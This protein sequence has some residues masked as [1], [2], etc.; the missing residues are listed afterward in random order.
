LSRLSAEANETVEVVQGAKEAGARITRFLDRASE[1]VSVCTD[2]RGLSIAMQMKALK[3]FRS[4]P[5][6]GL[7]V[8]FV[9]EI[10][11][12]NE[13]FAKMLSGFVE[14]RHLE[15]VAGIFAVSDAGEFISGVV[16][17]EGSPVTELV[18]SNAR[19]IVSQHSYLFE[20]LWRK[21]VPAESRMRELDQA[22]PPTRTNLLEG[23]KEV[24]QQIARMIDPAGEIV[25]CMASGG[26]GMVLDSIAEAISLAASE[27]PRG[28]LGR[29]RWLTSIDEDDAELAKACLALGVEVRHTSSMPPLS[30]VCSRSDILASIESSGQRTLLQNVLSSN[31]PAYVRHFL[32]LFEE[33]WKDGADAQKR[34][35][36]IASGVEP[37]NV[38]VIENP[39]ES[40][41]VAWEMIGTSREILLMFSTPR[42]FLRQAK[43]GAFETLKPLVGKS[44]SSVKILI[45][46]EESV[47]P[48]LEQVKKEV[49][50]ADFRVMNESL[51]T[52]ISILIADRSKTLVI[53]TSDDTKEELVGALGTAT[54]T[55]SR[56]LAAS[57]AAIFENI[58]KQTDMY[59]K[60]KLHEKLQ[61]DFVNVA[62]HELRTPV[63]A[64]INY[65]ELAA[66]D[67]RNK[68]E[69]Y[70]KL[71]R[72]VARLQRLTEEILDAAR[73]E[74]GTLRLNKEKFDIKSLVESAVEE[75]KIGDRA[76]G[77]TLVMRRS[78]SV[79]VDGDRGRM[80]QVVS[81]LLSNAVKF[82][83]A[84]SVTVSVQARS[85]E[86]R[87]RVQVADTGTGIDPSLIPMLFSRFVAKSQSGTGLGL[88]ISKS[89]IEEH[90]GRIW[91]ERNRPG[92]GATFAFEIPIRQIGAPAI[93]SWGPATRPLRPQNSSPNDLG[94]DL[95]G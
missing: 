6:E 36:A 34:I 90:G 31:D 71:L 23:G 41:R 2:R 65:A 45:P 66:T 78:G 29:I 9:T 7:K 17:Q 16:I 48:L 49:P 1:Q 68:D 12:E 24:V 77:V 80:G 85:R 18:Y 55:E 4:E 58:W 42:A 73:I 70:G 62:A 28:S 40:L 95:P 86:N 50:G 20:T 22:A 83:E 11:K 25:V 47:V 87:V 19:G 10:T 56:S 3:R 88:Y 75:Q 38:K 91:L 84:G 76:K 13:A 35:E 61:S 94:T 8:R 27:S 54:Y 33:M 21:A 67:A 15:G 32:S 82:T 26:V 37:S 5:R 44:G 46:Y 39:Q 79:V 57:Y 53:E 64:I 51:K 63:Q 74:G 59:D 30:F 52:R 60:L 93:H 69:Y 81:N 92:E 43:A 72:N 14:L 89:I